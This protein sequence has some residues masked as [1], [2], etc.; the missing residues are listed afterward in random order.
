MREFVDTREADV[1]VFVVK[2]EDLAGIYETYL[3]R[4]KDAL[5]GLGYRAQSGHCGASSRRRGGSR[6]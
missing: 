3:R 1:L 5:E 6:S 4:D 2:D